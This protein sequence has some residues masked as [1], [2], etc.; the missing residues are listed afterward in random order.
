MSVIKKL[1]KELI[2]KI[3]AGEVV[4]SPASVIKELVENSIDAF[5]S[6]IKINIEKGGKKRIVVSDNGCGIKSQELSLAFTKNAT[7]K[8][9]D[10]NSLASISTLGFRGEALF[11]IC[12][13]SK[14]SI[15]T[16]HKDDIYATK[17]NIEN[18]NVTNVKKVSFNNGTKIEVSDL[19]YNTPARLKHMKSEKAEIKNSLDIISKLAL[20]NPNVA[21]SVYSNGKEMFS[22]LGDG[23]LKNLIVATLGRDFIDK[24]IEVNYEDDPLFLNGYTLSPNFLDKQN[25]ESILIVNGRYVKNDVLNKAINSVY[26]E[27]YGSFVKR[28]SYILYIKIPYHFTDVNI[29]PS[30]TSISFRNETLITMLICEGIRKSLRSSINLNEKRIVKKNEEK[31]I[32][33]QIAFD[34]ASSYITNNNETKFHTYDNLLKK[35]DSKPDGLDNT[36]EKIDYF[37]KLD[38]V[39]TNHSTSNIQINDKD[40]TMSKESLDIN[41]NKEVFK[42]DSF[43]DNLINRNIF[44]NIINMKFVGFVFNAYATFESGEYLYVLDTHAGHERV[45]YDKYLQNSKKGNVLRQELMVPII[46]ELDVV[47]KEICLNNLDLFLNLG[48]KIENFSNNNIIIREIPD[49]FNTDYIKDQ[50]KD[51]L[52]CLKNTSVITNM[53]RDERLIYSACHSALRGHDNVSYEE[54]INILRD[55]S[56]TDNPFTCPH[57][58]PTISKISKK[59]FEKMFQ[60]I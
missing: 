52:Y 40:T 58:R 20:S 24:L 27:E 41:E 46:L 35:E 39:F 36:D 43:S 50:I 18:A 8:I 29:H 28:I 56:V 6:V 7:S 53:N 38:D 30:K 34:E 47:S 3:S 14:V 37:K 48:Y 22:T 54:A 26:K 10:V 44:E 12:V 4:V 25:E 60:R 21:F 32:I 1:D 57:S 11:S 16:K 17:A 2:N 9:D 49:V 23:N 45:L 55:L 31:D 59:N 13:V 33:S 5:A 51:M 19:F 15:I 42:E